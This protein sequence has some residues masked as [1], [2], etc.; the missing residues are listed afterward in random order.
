MSSAPSVLYPL[1]LPALLD[2]I[3]TT[4]SGTAPTTLIIC[5]SRDTFL[6]DLVHLLQQGDDEDQSQVQQGSLQQLV[7]PT[8]HNLLTARH[9]KL[10]FCGSVQALLAFLTA[11][12][13]PDTEHLVDVEEGARLLLVNPLALHASTPSFSAQGLSRTFAAA[14]ETALRTRVVLQVVECQ[15]MRRSVEEDSDQDTDMA[16]GDEQ[17]NIAEEDPWEQELSILN[18][19]ARRFGSGTAD[20]AWA[21]RTVKAKRVAGRWFHFHKLDSHHVREAPG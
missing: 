20:R 1:T 13:R 6:H 2:Y 14:T 3:L 4:Q 11:Y 17:P 19:S 16:N 9:V 10:A 5:S 7:T 8:L 12:G 18:V 21:G 15:G